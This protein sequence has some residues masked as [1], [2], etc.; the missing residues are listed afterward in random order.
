MCGVGDFQ[1]QE[2]MHESVGQLKMGNKKAG[3]PKVPD[4][5]VT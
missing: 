4:F 1:G 2:G 3:Y 5:C